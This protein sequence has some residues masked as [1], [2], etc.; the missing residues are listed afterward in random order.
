MAIGDSGT[1]PATDILGRRKI[2][3]AVDPTKSAFFWLSGF[4]VVYCARPE[5]WIPGLSYIPLAK[6]TAILAMWGL[7]NALGRTKRTLKDVPVEGKLLLAMIGLLFVGAFLSPVWRG[8]AI[9][10]TM[11]FSKVFIAWILTFL[12]ITTFQ[13]LKQIIYI[14]TASVAV[15]CFISVI[16]GHTRPRLEGVLGGI[17]S[18]PNDLAFSIVLTLPF[19]LAFL[20]TSRSGIAKICWII[21]MLGMGVALVLTASRAGFLNFIVSGTV[22]LW[23]FGVRGRRLYLIA[24][25]GL[26]GVLLLATAGGKLYDRFTALSG[27]TETEQS[28]Y[29]SYEARKYLMW[30]AVD[31][32]EN[33]PILGVGVSNFETYSLIWHQVHMTYLQVCVEGGIPVLILYLLFFRRAFKNLRVLRKA[34]KELDP[35]MILFAGALHSSLIGF[36]FGALFAPEGYQFFPYFAVAFTAVML[37]LYRDQAAEPGLAPPPKK[38]RHFLE[39]YGD[40]GRAG[41]IAPVR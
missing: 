33:Y 34:E 9:S 18:N 23:H 1:A 24:A 39:V 5:D 28:A 6:V 25:T 7:F 17:Y 15:I 2:L 35:E 29:E 31:G 10:H 19:V 36:V 3:P 30:R 41:A 27:D 12:L 26:I 8:G 16:K 20:L 22:T 40:Y 32:I 21:G 14:Q 13:R 38:P 37:Q 11:D 4:Y